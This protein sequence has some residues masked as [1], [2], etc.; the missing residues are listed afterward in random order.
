[1]TRSPQVLF[2]ESR[3]GTHGVNPKSEEEGFFSDLPP[4]EPQNTKSHAGKKAG[5]YI[6]HYSI[7]AGAGAGDRDRHGGALEYDDI[8]CQRG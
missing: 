3:S 1:M 7:A 8:Y 6:F 4:A 5:L 2:K